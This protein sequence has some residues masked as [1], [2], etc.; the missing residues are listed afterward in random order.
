[1]LARDG[2]VRD[3]VEVRLDELLTS[4]GTVKRRSSHRW[5]A[6]LA[7]LALV[8]AAC[9]SDDTDTDTSAAAPVTDA[10]STA[11]TT[12]ETAAETAETTPEEPTGE[13]IL[14]NVVAAVEGVVGQ[15]EIFDGAD[16]AV[17]SINA[18]GGIPDPEGGANRPLEIVRCEAGAGGSASPDV[19][20]ECARDTIDQGIIAVVSKYLIGADGTKAWQEAG[21]PLVGT[22]PIE[23]EDFTNPAVYPIAGGAAALV[24]G[25]GVALQEA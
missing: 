6:P 16:A 22:V 2:E 10:D 13:P 17:A 9:G 25:V 4:G 8:L 15:P 1:M 5:I 11:G 20:L 21:I 23:G 24:G 14:L 3:A 18:A 12:A 7:S 19:A